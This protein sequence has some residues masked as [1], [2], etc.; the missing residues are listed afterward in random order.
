[1]DRFNSP[2]VSGIEDR[3]N[4]SDWRGLVDSKN[5]SEFT[6]RSEA[7]RDRLAKIEPED[8]KSDE[9]GSFSL[10]KSPG[11]KSAIVERA[12]DRKLSNEFESKYITES[13]K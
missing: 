9:D 5:L 2:E 10:M 13:P 6:F 1:M 8:P 7:P 4:G 3:C 11:D 12:G